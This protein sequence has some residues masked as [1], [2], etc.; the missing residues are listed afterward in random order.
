MLGVE[1]RLPAALIFGIGVLIFIPGVVVFTLRLH[2]PSIVGLPSIIS[3]GKEIFIPQSFTIFCA[4]EDDATRQSTF[5]SESVDF[6][7]KLTAVRGAIE[8]GFG[9]PRTN[10]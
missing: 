8:V 4:I 7:A 1:I 9:M 10:V 3:L 5:G 6:G 2:G